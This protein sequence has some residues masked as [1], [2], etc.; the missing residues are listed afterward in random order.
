MTTSTRVQIRLQEDS[1]S[2]LYT[3][4]EDGV[5]FHIEPLAE[6][7]TPSAEA[8]SASGKDDAATTELVKSFL[9]QHLLKNGEASN[10]I[11]RLMR[12]ESVSLLVNAATELHLRKDGAGA[13]DLTAGAHGVGNVR[14]AIISIY[15]TFG[16]LVSMLQQREKAL[17]AAGELAEEWKDGV[18]VDEAE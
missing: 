2:I 12:A 13:G 17:V 1:G 7:I 15:K 5:I 16:T 10:T 9:R 4:S 6:S 18:E 14:T 3:D 8:G 11:Q